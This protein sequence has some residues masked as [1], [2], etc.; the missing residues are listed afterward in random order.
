M[1]QNLRMLFD[2]AIVDEPA[3]PSTD[4]AGA[5][6]AAGTSLRRRRQRLVTAGT[7]AVAA[8]AAVGVVNV[9]APPQRSAPEPTTVPAA[10]GMLVNRACEA[11]A[12]TTATDASIFLTDDITNGQRDAVNRALDV[13]PAVGTLVFVSREQALIN[14]RKM[15]E[16]APELAA[17]VKA[18]QFPESYRITLVAREQ[19][20][21][22]KGLV[23]RMP[24]VEEI[25]GIDC[26]AG[27]N[28]SAVD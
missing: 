21:T 10:F 22:L 2:R 13:D 25:I 23:K 15:Y 17:S 9:V 14:F 27:T 18:S 16:D 1:D 24:G 20:A 26:P 12:Q 7:A 6:M 5:A 3:L 4:L 11:P 8:I 19:F 28:A